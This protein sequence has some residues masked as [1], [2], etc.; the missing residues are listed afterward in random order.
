MAVAI[1]KKSSFVDNL[2][3]MWCIQE[4]APVDCIDRYEGKWKCYSSYFIY[5]QWSPVFIIV[6]NSAPLWHYHFWMNAIIIT[7]RA[8][9]ASL[10]STFLRTTTPGPNFVSYSDAVE[11]GDEYKAETDPH[12][13]INGFYVRNLRCCGI[14]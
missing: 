13:N 3:H 1:Y 6:T 14:Q 7:K 4:I 12:V 11:K 9:L 5:V 10:R 2:V 8:C